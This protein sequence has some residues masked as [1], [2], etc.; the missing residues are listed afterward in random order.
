MADSPLLLSTLTVI[1]VREQ[2]DAKCATDVAIQLWADGGDHKVISILGANSTEFKSQ[3]KTKIKTNKQ[4][5]DQILSDT[6][7]HYASPKRQN[8]EYVS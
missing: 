4:T 7:F 5:S 6:S 2:P 8:V 3:E 1:L